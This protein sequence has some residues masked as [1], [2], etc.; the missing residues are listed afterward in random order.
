MIHTLNFGSVKVCIL[1]LTIF[2]SIKMVGI[3]V[4]GLYRKASGGDMQ[5]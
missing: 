1:L 5:G 4:F 2:E 3:Y